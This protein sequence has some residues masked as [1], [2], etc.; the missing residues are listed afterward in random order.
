MSKLALKELSA[1]HR[2]LLCKFALQ[3]TLLLRRTSSFNAC[4]L[5]SHNTNAS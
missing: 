5:Y 4:A 1:L 3:K 2:D